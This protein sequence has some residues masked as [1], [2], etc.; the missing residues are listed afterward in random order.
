[1]QQQ[2]PTGMGTPPPRIEPSGFFTGVQIGPVIV[3]VVVDYIATQLAMYAFIFGY[4]AKELSQ[5]GEM[6]EEALAKYMESPEGLTVMLVIGCLGT[7]FGGFIAARRAATLE[8]KH[9][10][11]VGLGSLII[12]FVQHA[13]QE[14]SLQLPEW[15]NFV[16]IVAVIPAGALGGYAA[17]LLRAGGQNIS[18]RPP[19]S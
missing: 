18:T 2:T 7:A 8:I 14:H 4:L 5:Q 10:A 19:G 13:M 3:G 11:F 6:T 15:F 17:E 12:S 9:G 16:S 1:M